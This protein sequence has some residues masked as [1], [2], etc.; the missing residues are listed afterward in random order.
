L[1]CERDKGSMIEKR[2]ERMGGGQRRNWGQSKYFKSL[3]VVVGD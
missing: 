1:F 2:G 3:M